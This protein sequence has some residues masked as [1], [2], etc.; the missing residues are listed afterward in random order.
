MDADTDASGDSRDV[1]WVSTPPRWQS[2][3]TETMETEEAGLD[4]VLSPTARS[5]IAEELQRCRN[6]PVGWMRVQADGEG[7]RRWHVEMST[8]GEAGSS[9][10]RDLE[11]DLWNVAEVALLLWDAVSLVAPRVLDEHARLRDVLME[12]AT[13]PDRDEEN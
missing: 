8:F 3:R 1:E 5:R 2:L 6:M 9:A 12:I 10:G 4:A 7:G 11:Q 13:R